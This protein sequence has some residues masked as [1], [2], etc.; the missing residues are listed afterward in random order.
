MTFRRLHY[1]GHATA[2]LQTTTGTS[3]IMDPWLVDTLG[4]RH[5]PA[6][7]TNIGQLPPMDVITIS[8]THGDHFHSDSLRRLLPCDRNATVVMKFEAHGYM[9]DQ[10]VQMGFRKIVQLEHGESVS[11]RD[12]D[13]T[14]LWSHDRREFPS[15]WN[16]APVEQCSFLYESGGDA[17]F[18]GTD[19]LENDTLFA[20]LGKNVRLNVAL[21]PV[22]GWLLPAAPRV[23]D[24]M[25]PDQAVEAA[26]RLKPRIAVPYASGDAGPRRI[27][28]AEWSEAATKDA[29]DE[30]SLVV[31]DAHQEFVR[32]CSEQLPNTQ[33]IHLLPGAD[34][35]GR[36]LIWNG[37]IIEP[38]RR[39]P[40]NV[41]R[42]A[43][44]ETMI[45][46]GRKRV[47]LP[48]KIFD[49]Y[50]RCLGSPVHT[51]LATAIESGLDPADAESL[52]ASFDLAGILH[53]QANV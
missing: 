7:T 18:A 28:Y 46:T 33:A 27:P 45:D 2:V 50:A 36:G 16:S 9:L 17:I 15:P 21:L 29:S 13:I 37:A 47:R 23:R 39:Y 31:R 19:M 20:Q 44:G 40:E 30:V 14:C 3:L 12:V 42:L 11:I 4:I 32:R 22:S 34:L 5:E 10:L 25:G 38:G 35:P 49:W 53:V 48:G 43:N 26:R 24:V 1:V 6:A 8:H 51:A 41:A 52:L